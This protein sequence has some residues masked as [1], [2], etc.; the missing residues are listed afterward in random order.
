MLQHDLFGG[1]AYPCVISKVKMVTEGGFL[2]MQ[3]L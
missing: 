1:Y 3:Y 2:N